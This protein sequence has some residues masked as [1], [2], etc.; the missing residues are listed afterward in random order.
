MT[1]QIML[2]LWLLASFS[3]DGFAV[4]ATALGAKLVGQRRFEEHLVLCK[5]LVV[6][7]GA[8]GV[9]VSFCYLVGQRPIL[10]FFSQDMS[11]HTQLKT[12]WLLLV[13]TQPLNGLLYV[14]DGVLLGCKQFSFIRKVIVE[15]LVFVFLPLIVYGYYSSMSLLYLWVCLFALN[16]YR[17]AFG[18]C[19]V[20]LVNIKHSTFV[21]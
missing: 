2:Q 21:N 13:L 16:L 7:G 10:Y 4:T 12:L 17:L 5:R 18:F 20:F 1:H 19:R 11:L 9:L 14:L 15:G 3:M 8:M 6:L